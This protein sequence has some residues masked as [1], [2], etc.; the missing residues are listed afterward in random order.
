MASVTSRR[1]VPLVGN[2]AA[3][4]EGD[5]LIGIA[6]LSESRVKEW[7]VERIVNRDE[8]PMSMA[9]SHENSSAPKTTVAVSAVAKAPVSISTVAEAA[10]VR[11]V[12]TVIRAID[13]SL[14]RLSMIT[15]EAFLLRRTPRQPDRVHIH[16]FANAPLPNESLIRRRETIVN[17]GMFRDSIFDRGAASQE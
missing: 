13:P 14:C 17:V 9:S 12:F 10:V 2:H 7:I 5:C 3:V 15:A 8:A 1:S 6:H 4:R 11:V 16:S